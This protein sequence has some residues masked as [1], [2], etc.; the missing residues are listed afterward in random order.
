MVALYIVDQDDELVAPNPC[1]EIAATH[2]FLHAIGKSS[3]EFVSDGMTPGVIHTLETVEVE[4]EQRHAL[5]LSI[6][7]GE[8]TLG[9]L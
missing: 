6:R 7:I 5:A 1:G 4:V 3:E 8:R 2:G 9:S